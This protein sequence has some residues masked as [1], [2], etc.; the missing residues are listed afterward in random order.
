MQLRFVDSFKFLSSSLEKLVSYFDKSKLNI[1]RSKFF[2]LDEQE[3]A[4]LK[5]KGVF[6]YEY[7]NSFNKLNE[8]SLPPREAFYSSLIDEDISVDDY[9][10]ATDVWQR[11]RINTLGDYSDLYLKTDVLLLA[12]MFENFRD[13]YMESYGLDPAYYVILPS[14]TWDAMLKNSGVRFELLTDIDMVLFI[15]RGIRRGLSQCSHRYTRAN[16]VY[17]PTFDPSKPISYLVYFDVNN[18][19]GWAMME[20]LPY[21]ELP[22]E[23]ELH[24]LYTIT[25]EIGH[26]L[27]LSHNSHIDSLM[28]P[29]ATNKSVKLSI[30]DI[31]AIQRLYGKNLNEVPSTQSPPVTTDTRKTLTQKDLCDLPYVDNVLVLNHRKFV[32]YRRS[33][34][35]IAI[36]GKRYKAPVAIN[37]YLLLKIF[38]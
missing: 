1:T 18:L 10:H 11:F 20:P 29:Y 15:E 21:G 2:N 6:P 13:T 14:Y 16:N 31:L 37:D 36:N 3:F 28:F 7:V 19:Y 12:D 9:Q 4:F 27:G 17:V 32:T 5:R 22:S 38:L 23:N 24:L 34:W 8:T 26:S 25:H 35:M 30:E 33:M